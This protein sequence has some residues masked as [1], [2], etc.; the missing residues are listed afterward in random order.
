MSDKI[1]AALQGRQCQSTKLKPTQHSM[2]TDLVNYQ[3]FGS[4]P[5]CCSSLRMMRFIQ[6]DTDASPSWAK[7]CLIPSS[8]P[9]STR[10]AICLLPLPLISMVD[11][12]LTPDY[13]EM[14]IKCMT[15]AY[16]KATPRT[17]GAV[18]RRLT[19]PLYEVTIMAD[20]KSTQTRLEFTWRFLA[21]TGARITVVYTNACTESEARANCPGW[22]LVFAARFPLHQFEVV[23]HG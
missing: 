21:T 4:M 22:K 14:V 15:G 7:A 19:K 18:P 10:N 3:P 16:Q 5:R 6:A 20:I 17:V 1:K 9:G 13:L 12:W 11:I 23:H 8:K 2:L